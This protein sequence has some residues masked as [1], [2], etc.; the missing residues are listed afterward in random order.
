MADLDLET[1]EQV[2]RWCAEAVRQA[3]TAE[4]RAALG[5]LSWDEVL[6]LRALLADPPPARPL[7]PYALADL[8]RGA[9]LD[10]VQEKEDT[11]VR[12]Q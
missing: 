10:A 4:I 8:A 5:G 11:N 1:V 12:P 7:G 2:A 3:G 9:P 6:A